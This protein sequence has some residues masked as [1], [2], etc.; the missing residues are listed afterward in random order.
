MRITRKGKHSSLPPPTRRIQCCWY[1]K[2]TPSKKDPEKEYRQ[3]SLINGKAASIALTGLKGPKRRGTARAVEASGLCNFSF[4]LGMDSKDFFIHNGYG[5]S[6]H[7]NYFLIEEGNQNFTTKY[8]TESQMQQINYLTQASA[9]SGTKQQFIYNKTD[10]ILLLHNIWSLCQKLRHALLDPNDP[11][12]EEFSSADNLINYFRANGFDHYC[13][14]HSTT[15][16]SELGIYTK[17][18]YDKLGDQNRATTN[19]VPNFI[20]QL[21][22]KERADLLEYINSKR[23]IMTLGE[24]QYLIVAVT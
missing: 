20:T 3:T 24:N 10:R 5:N 21:N 16:K 19:G 2:H 18:C 13:L 9:S 1:R 17:N 4:V 14:L 22:P 12:V 7:R 23:N 11:K 6:C 15:I 8:F